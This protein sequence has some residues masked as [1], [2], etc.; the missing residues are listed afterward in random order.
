MAQLALLTLVR[1]KETY[2]WETGSILVS[3]GFLWLIT[4][5]QC[6]C[7]QELG[8]SD[9]GKMCGIYR[10]SPEGDEDSQ[11]AFH[12]SRGCVCALVAALTHTSALRLQTRLCARG[13]SEVKV[14]RCV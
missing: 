6:L 3:R 11:P 4:E 7:V 9:G 10:E 13:A 12:E 8:G 1:G 2:Q 14:Q 5:G